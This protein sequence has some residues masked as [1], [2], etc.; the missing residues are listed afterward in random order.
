V[1]RLGD[2]LARRG[3]AL[4]PIVEHDGGLSVDSPMAA[5]TLVP[6]ALA[7]AALA[8]PGAA[9]E[10]ALG[11]AVIALRASATPGASPEAAGS[12]AAA[13]ALARRRLEAVGARLEI[14]RED[15]RIALAVRF[16]APRALAAPRAAVRA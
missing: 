2:L 13:L 12:G 15:D 16:P 4:G 14:A 6:L 8:E 3:F 10:V 7:L 9:V 11:A 1:A 5:D